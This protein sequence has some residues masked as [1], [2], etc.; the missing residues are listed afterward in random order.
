MVE[1][2]KWS[3]C[4]AI[5]HDCK[6]ENENFDP[7]HGERAAEFLKSLNGKVF[8]LSKDRFNVLYKAFFYHNKGAV[9]D[10]PTIGACWDA[11]RLELPRVGIP[12]HASYMSTDEGTR[13]AMQSG[14]VT[15]N[16][17]YFS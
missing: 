2:L 5:F 7:E 12:P 14:G 3:G 13:L 8:N 17:W 6:R 9:D 16:L 11:D 4:F 1:T 10:N 15:S